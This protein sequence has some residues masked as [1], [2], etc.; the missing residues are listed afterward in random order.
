M[1]IKDFMIYEKIDELD[2]DDMFKIVS[3][4]YNFVYVDF[5]GCVKETELDKNKNLL[6]TYD[7]MGSDIYITIDNLNNINIENL[8]VVKALLNNYI[9]YVFK[10]RIKYPVCALD[11]SSL[12]PSIIMTYNISPEYWVNEYLLAEE[13]KQKNYELHNIQFKYGHSTNEEDINSWAIKKINNED[14]FGLYPSILKYLFD[15]RNKIKK[16]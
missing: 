4:L 14:M 13:L 10:E 1:N 16:Y 7:C 5:I 2:V 9:Q 6:I 15:E 12:Y 8:D 11:F 3:K